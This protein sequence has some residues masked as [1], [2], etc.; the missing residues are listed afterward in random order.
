MPTETH[1]RIPPCLSLLSLAPVAQLLSPAQ[2]ASS[3]AHPHH[4]KWVRD[5]HTAPS[6][7][8]LGV[9]CP[10]TIHHPKGTANLVSGGNA[11]FC[12]L[13]LGRPVPLALPGPII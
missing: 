7:A 3:A 11:V 2:D 10:V 9:A 12:G 1:A 5:S 4:R 8:L 13:D 6:L